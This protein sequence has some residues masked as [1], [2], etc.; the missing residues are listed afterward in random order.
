VETTPLSAI[1]VFIAVAGLLLGVLGSALG[2]IGRRRHQA[3]EQRLL[4]IEEARKSELAR[5]AK[6]ARLRAA[7]E[8]QVEA[9]VRWFVTIQNHGHGDA[10]ALTVSINGSPLDHCDLIDPKELNPAGIDA[11]A[12]HGG[13]RIP[14]QV[15][16]R[17]QELQVELTWSDASGELGFYQAK[18]TG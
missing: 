11:V 3:L 18:L 2:L 1:S 16:D 14:L 9:K 17:P 6:R 4:K 7:I 10:E 13:L 15:A 12:A 5:R 8:E